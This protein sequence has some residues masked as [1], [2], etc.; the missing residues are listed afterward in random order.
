MK[1][2]TRKDIETIIDNEIIAKYSIDVLNK[3]NGG[4]EVYYRN[5]LKFAMLRFDFMKKGTDV[6]INKF[7][8]IIKKIINNV[9]NKEEIFNLIDMYLGVS[10]DEKKLVGEVFT[11]FHIVRDVLSNVPKDFWTVHTNKVLDNSCGIGNFE[12]VAIEYFMEGLKDWEPNEEKR[13]KHI[14]ENQIHVC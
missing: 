9:R 7:L 8:K 5:F 4:V 10:E 11:S 12:V 2:E 1:I 3:I 6:K 14:I 13:Y